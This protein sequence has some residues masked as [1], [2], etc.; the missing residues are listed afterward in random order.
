MNQEFSE[1]I[2]RRREIKQHKKKTSFSNHT[3]P[4]GKTLE[5]HLHELNTGAACRP[6]RLKNKAEL[7]VVHVRSQPEPDF[8]PRVRSPHT[9]VQVLFEISKVFLTFCTTSVSHISC[10]MFTVC[11][12]GRWEPAL[13]QPEASEN[14]TGCQQ[15]LTLLSTNDKLKI[16]VINCRFLKLSPEYSRCY[17]NNTQSYCG[18]ILNQQSELHN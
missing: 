12:E 7:V 10:N 16:I 8:R 5:M 13:N 11:C 6:R 3:S 14:Q 2:F 9:P 1:H 4:Q 18:V 15:R 17:G